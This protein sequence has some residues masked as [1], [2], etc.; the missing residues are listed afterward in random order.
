[1][2]IEKNIPFP[3][4]RG[5]WVEIAQK[6]E[7]GDSVLVKTTAEACSLGLAVKRA[8]NGKVTTAKQACGNIRVWRKE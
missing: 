2:K 5:K 3:N 8:V 4:G 7:V 1:M 6:M